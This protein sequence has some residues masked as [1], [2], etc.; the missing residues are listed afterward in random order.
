MLNFVMG[1]EN[2][3][4]VIAAYNENGKNKKKRIQDWIVVVV[5]EKSHKSL[6]WIKE[7]NEHVVVLDLH[8]VLRG[9]M[10]VK[11]WCDGRWNSI[12][13]KKYIDS[14]WCQVFT[15]SCVGL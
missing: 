7:K 12:H 3:K 11:L 8:K 1:F 10:K 14:L 15:L 13:L 9:G 2:A 6:R 5:L 4:E